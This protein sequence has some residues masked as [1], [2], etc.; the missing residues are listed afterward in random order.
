MDAERSAGGV[1]HAPSGGL[2]LFGAIAQGGLGS[3]M[4]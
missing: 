4:Q 2:G 1:E 3:L